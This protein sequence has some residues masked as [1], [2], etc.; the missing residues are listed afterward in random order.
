MK[1]KLIAFISFAVFSFIGAI[2]LKEA[3]K[4]RQSFLITNVEA[5][6]AGVNEDGY[7]T[8]DCWDLLNYRKGVDTRDCNGCIK[9][10]N[11]RPSFPELTRQ[12][13]TPV[14]SEE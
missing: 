10:T 14:S 5:L 4:N 8:V 6:A 3:V 9:R 2:C 13:N 12:C 1:K 11:Q 7:V